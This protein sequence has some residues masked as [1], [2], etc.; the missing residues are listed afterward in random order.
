[1]EVPPIEEPKETRS[2][3]SSDSPSPS[4]PL[5]YISIYHLKQ[6][7]QFQISSIS[8]PPYDSPFTYE[9]Y[10]SIEPFYETMIHKELLCLQN[11]IQD[12]DQF[13]PLFTPDC[14]PSNRSS[15]LSSDEECKYH[16][17]STISSLYYDRLLM[18]SMH[19][20]IANHGQ[21]SMSQF[22]N[23]PY[24]A[25]DLLNLT[26]YLYLALQYS[27]TT[28]IETSLY[29][30][31]QDSFYSNSIQDQIIILYKYTRDLFLS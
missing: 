25:E 3:I 15:P 29:N 7:I 18:F 2:T 21:L 13:I 30:Q 14:L 9:H 17:Y 22:L 4:T 31:L 12:H 1:M 8:S 23:I 24:I 27:H 20:S 10:V 16:I 5:Q 28:Q 11:I 6:D 26:I 19:C